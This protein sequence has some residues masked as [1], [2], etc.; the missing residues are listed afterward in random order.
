MALES[1][2]REAEAPPAACDLRPHRRRR[3]R[4]GPGLPSAEDGEYRPPDGYPRLVILD[5][6]LPRVSGLEV[7]RRLKAS[8]RT[9]WIPIVV[10]TSSQEESDLIESYDLGANGYV[11]KPV[12]FED[13]MKAVDPWVCS[14]C[15]P[16]RRPIDRRTIAVAQTERIPSL[17]G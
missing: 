9:K 7:L 8:P 5:L 14:G 12:D 11:V 4:R 15:S 13:F 3:R 1:Y 6:K 2:V 17:V 10:M 16:T